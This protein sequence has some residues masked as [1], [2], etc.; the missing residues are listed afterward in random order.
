MQKVKDIIKE[1]VLVLDG[2]MG[3]MVQ[4]YGLKETDFR[5]SQFKDHPMDLMG[6]N[7]ILSI[8]RPDIISEIHESYLQ[9]GADLIETNTF[10][11]NSISQADY[12]MEHMVYDLNLQSA[13]IAKE[14][15]DRFT[16]SNPNKPRFVCGAI[17]PTN[18]TASMSPD[19][20][21]PGHRNVDF[22]QLVDAY[23]EQAKG[24][25]DGGVDILMIET[26]FDTLNCKAAL[27][28][29]QSLF[30]EIGKKIPVIVS[31][32]ITDASGRLLS[33]QT[34][35]A[36]WHSIFHMDLLAVGLN[37]ALGAEEM[38]PYLAS[39]SKV[40]DTYTIA[41]P[42]AGLP[43]EFGGYDESADQMA[44]QL[45][46]FIDSGLVNI[47]G[48]CCGATP[49]HIKA[50]SSIV[51]GKKPRSVS[52]V[53][54]F[55]K[56]SGLEPLVI[57]PES[58]FINVGERTNVTGS[59][60]FKRLIKEDKFDEALSVA[61]DQV[62]NGAQIID[63]NLD[64]GL[65]DSENA[66]VRYLRLISSEP[67]ISKVP[68][69]IDSSKWSVIESGLKNIQ[70]KGI[71]NSI[72]LKEG[73]DEFIRQAK[74][75][76]QYGAAVIVMAF[77]EN[78]QADTFERKVE[79][80]QRAFHI[81]TNKVM[82]RDEDII[83]DP[84]IFAVATGIEEHNQYGKAYID[85]AKKIR[86][87]MP[88]VHVSGGVS[89][90]SFSF[91]GNDTV[92]EAM[93]SCFLYHATS[94][95]MD[96]GIV[97]PGQ[98]T[99]YDDI[100]IELRDA[101]EDVLFDRSE[102]ATDNL[103]ALAEKYRGT[104]KE[105][106][107]NDEWRNLPIK[108]RL[109]YS[110]IEGLDK[111]IEEDTEVARSELDSPIEV[112]E[113]PLMDGMN[114]V[115]DLFGEGKM[116]LPQVVKSARVMKKAVA[117]L[118]PFIEDEK[119]G[120]GVGKTS[121]GTIL[122]ATVKGD[123][124]DIGKNIVGV[125]LGCNGYS[126]VDMG[127]MVPADKILSKAKEVKADIIGLS[128]LITPSLEEMVHVAS[129]MK[130]L[131]FDVPLLIGGA[132]TSVKHTAVK[133]EEKYPH[134]VFHVQDASR[135][136]GF[137]AKLLKPSEK[138]EL[139]EDTKNK[140]SSIKESFY[141]NQKNI[142][143]LSIEDARLRK[144][145]LEY[146]PFTPKKL[147]S[148]KIEKIPLSA[149]SNYIDWS[150]LFHAWELSGVYPKIFDHPTKG[151]EAKKVF[152]DAQHLL[153]SIIKDEKLE[154]KAVY[155][156][157][158][159]QSHSEE[160]KLFEDQT[161]FYFP[162]QLMDKGSQPNFSLA[163]YISPTGDDHIGL[164]AVTAGHGIENIIKEY[165]AKN[166]D[167]SEIMAKVLADRLAEATA[168]WLHKKVRTEYWGYSKDEDLD[169]NAMLY[170][171]YCGIRPAPGYPACPD[172]KEKD[173]IWKLLNVEEQIGISLTESRAMF[174]AASVC[175]WY[176]SHPKARYFSVL[177]NEVL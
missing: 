60:R 9:A 31:G 50:F 61:R 174:P 126:I 113:G 141:E 111:F 4:G 98:L 54:S 39:L 11:A 89:N 46:E 117:Y 37:C 48:G 88:K 93:H 65:I 149:L 147:G 164:F 79:I 151:A 172:H 62:E 153:Q 92:R 177:K 86:E 15:S 68:I 100:D 152:D 104:K 99:V 127:V 136:V 143:L 59:L 94:N 8:T 165:Q 83:F 134:C 114:R 133:I 21:D 16:K 145:A 78:G 171:K 36:F 103:V 25:F 162:R 125:V 17:G 40:S 57:R 49:D 110:L 71:V 23:K 90:L 129:E 56:L 10:N 116:F 168:E 14:I 77:D 118:I 169:L 84:N 109:S 69:M 3:T 157:F 87:L 35:E 170:E 18:Q 132:T 30:K 128:G 63:I 142:N 53:E 27:F 33:G 122:L 58:N 2:P 91:R 42:N 135:C 29:I 137:V 7:D 97:N 139:I 138:I 166:D 140:Y 101:I 96:M 95:G 81:L 175:G 45:S 130:R 131:N 146:D 158:K 154:A 150:P 163:D 44:T 20:S 24:L 124:H 38:R 112:I 34:V 28:A 102:N 51:E 43:N 72:S 148:F 41:Y 159:A 13:K 52:S 47:I 105:K 119:R 22:D 120:K 19:V 67:D 167:Y 32:T 55:T 107:S 85:A 75:V 12:Q 76:K 82:M 155:G 108:E 173:K 123:V 66:M 106:K 80:C 6:N 176:F 26:V 115:G 156:F 70:G 144:P 1:R 5:G 161:S 73:E 121:N 64:E 160:V 74:L